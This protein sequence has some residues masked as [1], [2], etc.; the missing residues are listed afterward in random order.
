VDRFD[1]SGVGPGFGC[2]V[3]QSIISYLERCMTRSVV[4]LLVAVCMMDIACWC[5]SYVLVGSFEEVTTH[6]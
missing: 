1:A 5:L 6:G 2:G 3:M 4:C